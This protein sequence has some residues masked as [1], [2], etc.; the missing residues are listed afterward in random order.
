MKPPEYPDSPGNHAW[1]GF[2]HNFNTPTGAK[3]DGVGRGLGGQIFGAM[4]NNIVTNI[5]PFN[6]SGNIK[7]LMLQVSRYRQLQHP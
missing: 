4:L 6:A 2:K 3:G 1:N 5:E 7:I